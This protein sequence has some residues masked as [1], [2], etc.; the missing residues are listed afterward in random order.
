MVAGFASEYGLAHLVGVKTPGKLVAA[1]SFKVGHGYRVVLPVGAYFTWQ[2]TKLEGRGL[3][4]D[5]IEPL[6]AEALALG[7]D[8]QFVRALRLLS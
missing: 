5:S 4:P 6:C 7:T 2:G 3:T 8:T 1:S